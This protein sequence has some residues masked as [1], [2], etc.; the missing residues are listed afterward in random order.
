MGDRSHAHGEPYL[1]D[2]KRTFFLKTSRALE[3]GTL[4]ILLPL[5]EK[6]AGDKWPPDTACQA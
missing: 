3:K 6:E 1:V 4:G 2:S 5:T